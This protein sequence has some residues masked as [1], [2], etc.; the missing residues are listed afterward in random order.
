MQRL[1]FPV[2]ALSQTGVLHSRRQKFQVSSH[3]PAQSALGGALSSATGAP[4]SAAAEL[5]AGGPP[6]LTSIMG[7][8]AAALVGSGTAPVARTAVSPSSKSLAALSCCRRI[9]AYS[10]RSRV[11]PKV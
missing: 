6:S 11:C 4:A 10:T 9:I 7:G 8:G 3:S 1:Y 5:A 2:H